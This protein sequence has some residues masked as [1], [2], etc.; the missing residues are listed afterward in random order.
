MEIDD[1]NSLT[2][3]EVKGL[4]TVTGR[5]IGS[6]GSQG[7]RGILYGNNKVYSWQLPWIEKQPENIQFGWHFGFTAEGKLL[8]DIA[9]MNTGGSKTKLHK[10]KF[11][12]ANITNAEAQLAKGKEELANLEKEIAAKKIIV[13]NAH[14]AVFICVCEPFVAFTT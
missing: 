6:K 13:D 5:A 8:C 10:V 9:T 4:V 1:Q 11:Y 2:L 14:N 3:S 7:G 12:E